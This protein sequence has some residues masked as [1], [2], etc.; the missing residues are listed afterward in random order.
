[1]LPPLVFSSIALTDI[2]RR[3]LDRRRLCQRLVQREIIAPWTYKY[4]HISPLLQ[5]VPIALNFVRPFSSSILQKTSSA[6]LAS[7]GVV[8]EGACGQ[9]RQISWLCVGG[10][11]CR[12]RF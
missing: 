2:F 10:R 7:S 4:D 5:A 11:G 12:S 3:L 1:M 9:I 6:Y 8:H